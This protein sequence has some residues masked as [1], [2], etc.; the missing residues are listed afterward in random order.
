MGGL[1][2]VSGELMLERKTLFAA[3]VALVMGV[4][5]AVTPGCYADWAFVRSVRQQQ[6]TQLQQQVK[7]LAEENAQ[8][9][10]QLG[11]PK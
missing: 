8:L 1:H 5:G 4:L 10:A 7:A 11:A 6:Q 2:C 3:G 9:K